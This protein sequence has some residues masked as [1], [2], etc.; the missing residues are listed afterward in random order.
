[1][2][3]PPPARAC[4]TPPACSASL[5]AL[6]HVGLGQRR[7]PSAS[8]RR[9]PDL[10]NPCVETFNTDGI[11]RPVISKS[12]ILSAVTPVYSIRQIAIRK[13]ERWVTKLWEVGG[14]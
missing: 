9:G 3:E 10:V 1:M 5:R 14:V 2:P 13:E 7:A 12:H 6:P 11:L 4:G 8:R